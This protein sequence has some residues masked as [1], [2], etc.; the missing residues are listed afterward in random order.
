MI[1]RIAF[2]V[3]LAFAATAAAQTA[4]PKT[5]TPAQIAPP[6][7]LAQVTMSP[8]NTKRAHLQEINLDTAMKLANACVAYSRE[9]NPN[10]GASVVIMEP[11]G[12]V[13]FAMR[14]DGQAP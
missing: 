13:V 5:S 14:S 7:T 3:A 10:G 6:A 1:A 2:V 11:S 12:S 9:H 8:D 4:P